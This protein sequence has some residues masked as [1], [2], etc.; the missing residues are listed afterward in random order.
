MRE[1]G[2]FIGGKEVK[3]GSGRF[4][5]VFSGLRRAPRAVEEQIRALP[6]VAEVEVRQ[7]ADVRLEVRGSR[8]PIVGHLVSLPRGGASRLDRTVLRRGRPPTPRGRTRCW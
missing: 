7:V 3:G 2:H 8:E 4:A 5:D 6:G 1:I